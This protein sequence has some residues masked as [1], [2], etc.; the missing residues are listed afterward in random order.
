MNCVYQLDR[1]LNVG[2]FT[3]RGCIE[4]FNI[5]EHVSAIGQ[6][7]P[8]CSKH[9]FSNFSGFHTQDHHCK[10]KKQSMIKIVWGVDSNQC[11]GEPLHQFLVSGCATSYTHQLPQL[12]SRV[13]GCVECCV[14]VCLCFC[15]AVFCF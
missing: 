3:I 11:R 9:N 8:V 5:E 10:T 2:G 4:K 7:T 14:V 6:S 1:I 12:L 15:T 13:A